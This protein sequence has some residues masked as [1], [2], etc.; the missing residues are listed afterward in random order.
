MCEFL[1]CASGKCGVMFPVF[2]S[3]LISVWTDVYI[4]LLHP[5]DILTTYPFTKISNWSSGNTYFHI[6][7]G[8]LVQGSKLLCETSLVREQWL[9]TF[10]RYGLM[11]GE[12]ADLEIDFPCFVITGLQNGWPVDVLHQPDADQYEQAAAFTRPEQVNVWLA[13]GR[14]AGAS[15]AADWSAVQLGA[16]LRVP[17]V[18]NEP[19]TLG[20]LPGLRVSRWKLFIRLQWGWLPLSKAPAFGKW[21]LIYVFCWMIGSRI[22]IKCDPAAQ[23]QS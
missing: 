22:S 7:I 21:C 15:A 11:K 1:I 10:I 3:V 13:R 16:G 8:N 17:A 4:P 9:Q 19:H 23:K 5:Q 6:T 14:G 20:Q 18:A 2:L 12:N